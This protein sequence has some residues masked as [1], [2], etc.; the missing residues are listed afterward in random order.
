M[1]VLIGRQSAVAAAGERPARDDR[2]GRNGGALLSAHQCEAIPQ[3][4]P[5]S[6]ERN[7]SMPPTKTMFGLAG[8]TLKG[9]MALSYQP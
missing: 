5:P 2:R 9:A 7:R 6:S 1:P 8:S 3:L 4:M